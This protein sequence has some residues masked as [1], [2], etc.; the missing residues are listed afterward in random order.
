MCLAQGPQPSDTGEARTRG[1]L[2]SSQAFYHRA[3]ALP[4]CICKIGHTCLIFFSVSN[5][6]LLVE[7]VNKYLLIIE[8]C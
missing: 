4:N 7:T 3:T 5:K 1:L 2:V 8:L 6:Y